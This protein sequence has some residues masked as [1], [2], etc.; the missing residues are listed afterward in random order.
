MGWFTDDSNLQRLLA[1]AGRG[2]LLVF[3][4]DAV[5]RR[6]TKGGVFKFV[7]KNKSSGKKAKKGRKAKTAEDDE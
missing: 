1:D 3:K 2:S 6:I 5:Y 4:F 7:I